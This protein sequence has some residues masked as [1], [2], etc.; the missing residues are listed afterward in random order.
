MGWTSILSQLFW[1][2]QK[3]F[4]WVL[5]HCHLDLGVPWWLACLYQ[6]YIYP[7][8]IHGMAKKH[9]LPFHV[10]VHDR[11]WKTWACRW[12]RWTRRASFRP[13]SNSSPDAER[14]KSGVV[15]RGKTWGDE[16]SL[17]EL[18]WIYNTD[19]WWKLI[20]YNMYHYNYW[21]MSWK[22]TLIIIVINQH[23]Y[24]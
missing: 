19:I 15:Q 2:E 13:W 22:L 10:V 7:S 12:R 9:G 14:L 24:S 4:P 1:C 5:T 21:Y 17:E 20:V 16:T 3:G 11:S 23:I 6:P 8:E 18:S